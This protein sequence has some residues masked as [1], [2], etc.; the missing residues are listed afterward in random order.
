MKKIVILMFLN[1]SLLLN[2]A[3]TIIMPKDPNNPDN[4]KVS[5]D[6]SRENDIAAAKSKTNL[7]YKKQNGKGNKAVVENLKGFYLK[8]SWEDNS[9]STQE[10][11]IDFVKTIK[12]KGYTM[13]K[14]T[15]DKLSVVYY[16][17]YLFDITLKDGKVINDAKGRINEIESFTAYNSIGKEKCYT[18]FIRYW[19]EDKQFYSDNKSKDYLESPDV[20]GNVVVMINFN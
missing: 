13:V 1:L 16:F 12:I 18:Y 14:K 6:E 17:P 10:V 15:K 3:D 8:L 4:P 11:L 19:L 7:E 5:K 2:A 9:Y 20:P